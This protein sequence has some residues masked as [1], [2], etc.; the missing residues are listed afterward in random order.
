MIAYSSLHR[1][2]AMLTSTPALRCP[3]TPTPVS[4]M[5]MQSNREPQQGLVFHPSLAQV[6]LPVLL[7]ATN[8]GAPVGGALSDVDTDLIRLIPHRLSQCA[9]QA[10]GRRIRVHGPH[11]RQAGRG[12]PRLW[13]HPGRG[14]HYRMLLIRGV[15]HRRRCGAVPK[16]LNRGR[17]PCV[18]G[19]CI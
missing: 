1:P 8:R 16:G 12:I 14:N 11:E 6:F 9:Q 3:M 15:H 19:C 4:P 2:G 5:G 18:E 7:S 10:S 13:S 17:N